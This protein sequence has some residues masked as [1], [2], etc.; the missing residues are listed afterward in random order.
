[1]FFQG[2]MFIAFP[3]CSLDYIYSRGYTYS[4]VQASDDWVRR[5]GD[6]LSFTSS[7]VSKC[8]ITTRKHCWGNFQCKKGFSFAI[9]TI[10]SFAIIKESGWI[11]SRNDILLHSIHGFVFLNWMKITFVYLLRWLTISIRQAYRPTKWQKNPVLYTVALLSCSLFVLCL[12][13]QGFT[14][15]KVII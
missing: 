8:P 13:S 11:I 7:K 10:S 15:K 14:D 2:A 6:L 12:I 4:G 5:V 1:M 3:K 9:F